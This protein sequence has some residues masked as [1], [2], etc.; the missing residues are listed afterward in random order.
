MDWLTSLVIAA[1]GAVIVIAVWFGKLPSV[2]RARIESGG[3]PNLV[4][5]VSLGTAVL[6][7]AYIA[8]QLPDHL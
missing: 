5:W 1:V 8:N 6:L 2:Q 7:V 3:H 4:W